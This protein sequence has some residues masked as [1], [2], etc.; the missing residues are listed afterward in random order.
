MR[1]AAD[2]HTWVQ[3]L[4]LI[5][6]SLRV[7]MRSDGQPSP[8]ELVYGS[9]L[10][11]PADLLVPVS[12]QHQ[13][14]P[15]D[16]ADRLREHMQHVKPIVT[17]H[18]VSAKSY[19]YVDSNLATCRK[20]FIKNMNKKGLNFNYKGPYDVVARSPKYLT[21]KLPNGMLDNVT[22]D[23]IKACFTQEEA[24]P[25]P[26]VEQFR[27]VI[28]CDPALNEQLPFPQEQDQEQLPDP[29]VPEAHVPPDPPGYTTRFGRRTKMPARYE[30]YVM[31]IASV[32]SRC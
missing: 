8:S 10:T 7:A 3:R 32:F 18:N 1:A 31:Y 21:I 11:L 23:R 5:M 12:L 13:H 14:N 27:E 6:L 16:Y 20:V 24:L 29:V 25:P 9:P 15:A 17:K 28:V 19:S 2:D 4:P 22:V 26:A 30:D